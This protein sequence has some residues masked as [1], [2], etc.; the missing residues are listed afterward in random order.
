MKKVIAAINM[1]LDGVFD[2][3]AIQPD[4]EVHQHYTDLLKDSEVI[5]YGRITFELMKYWQTFLKDPSEEKSMNDFAIAIDQIPKI[6]FSNKLK[7]TDWDTARLATQDIEKEVLVLKES[8]EK[9]ILLGS[10]SMINQLMKWDLID[11]YQF[12]VHPLIAGQGLSL[13]EEMHDRTV[14]KLIKTKIFSSGAIILYYEP[15]RG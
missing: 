7:D 11:E 15:L 9:D 3:T 8:S 14:L 1:T 10:R 4:E 13:F 5:L 2:H 12:C 6:V